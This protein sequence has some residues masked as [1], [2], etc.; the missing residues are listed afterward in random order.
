MCALLNR[1]L[2]SHLLTVICDRS[3]LEWKR[4]P[5]GEMFLVCLEMVPGVLLLLAKVFLTLWSTS[6]C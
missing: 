2:N 5:D 3:W 1:L 6:L 4:E